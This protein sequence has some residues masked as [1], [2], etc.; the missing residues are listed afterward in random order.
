MSEVVLEKKKRYLYVDFIRVFAIVMVML[1]HCICDYYNDIANSSNLLWKVLSY[2]NELARTGVPLFFM[3]SGFLLLNDDIKSTS[4][5]YKKRF[6]KVLIPFLVYDIFYYGLYSYINKNPMTIGGFFKELLVSGSA[7]HLWFIYSIL[8]LYLFIPFIKKIVDASSQKMLW[9]FLVL[10]TF[11]TTLRPFINTIFKDSVYIYF[12]DDGFVGYLGYMILGYILG[13]YDYKKLTNLIIILLGIVSFIC[14][15][16]VTMTDAMK[17]G[18]FTFNG[19]YS[20]NH[21]VE[22]AALFILFKLIIKNENK[23]VSKLSLV[24]FEAYFI[25]VFVIL[26]IKK[27]NFVNLSPAYLMIIWTVLTV[28]ISFA[29]GFIEKFITNSFRRLKCLKK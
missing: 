7:Y 24:T 12:A 28:I 11:Q 22:A 23:F 2:V 20:L 3:I 1:L 5:F 15:P 6:L 21:Y 17:I 10:V 4:L 8:I 26:A 14:V 27:I 18:Q 25:H 19:G 9:L 13:K 16:L 29:W